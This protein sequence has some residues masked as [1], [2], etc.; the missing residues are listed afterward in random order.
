MADLFSVLLVLFYKRP[1]CFARS[2]SC[3]YTGT[4]YCFS[5]T[6]LTKV[7]VVFVS[8]SMLKIEQGIINQSTTKPPVWKR[9]NDYVSVCGKQAKTLIASQ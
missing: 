7:A 5:E 9:Y 3:Y 4:H 1:V 6:V 2:C 8:I